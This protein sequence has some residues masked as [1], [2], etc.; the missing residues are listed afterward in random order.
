MQQLVRYAGAPVTLVAAAHVSVCAP[1]VEKRVHAFLASSRIEGEW[2]YL[3]L[4][5]RTLANLVSQA[6]FEI[7]GAAYHEALHPRQQRLPINGHA[8]RQRRR[9]LRLSQQALAQQSGCS[10]S[11]ISRLEQR[12]H[13]K[14]SAELVQAIARAL[15]YAHGNLAHGTPYLV[16]GETKAS[17]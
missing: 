2:F 5:Q 14:M 13:D 11:L 3:H 7:A 1:Q 12:G 9:M 17:A 15:G 8:V 4:N 10:P 16:S 6:L